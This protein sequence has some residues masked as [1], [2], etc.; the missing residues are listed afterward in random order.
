MTTLPIA[1]GTALWF[2][3]RGTGVVALLLATLVVVLGVANVRRVQLEGVPR[4]VVELVHRNAAL[5]AVAFLVVHVLTSVLDPFAPITLIDAVV[6]F[7]SA[8]RP[9]WLGLGAIASDLLLAIV[10]TSLVRRRLGHRA[11]RAIHWLAY[12]SWPVAVIHSLGTGSDAKTKWLLALTALCVIVVVAA[13]V[14]R[15]L[16]GWPRRLGARLGALGAAA[17]LPIGLLIWLPSGPLGRD[18]ARRSGTP[19]SV[20]AA[21]HGAPVA[22]GRRVS[23]VAPTKGTGAGPTSFQATVQGPLARSLE[24]GGRA[25]IQLL[26]TVAGERLSS[27]DVLIEGDEIAGGGVNMTSSSVTLGTASD[28]HLYRG[29]ITALNGTNITAVVSDAAGQTIH[30]QIDLQLAPS[31]QSAQGTVT[32]SA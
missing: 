2:L 3:T 23:R 24:G 27:L 1:S 6:P 25:S 14:A 31:G 30:L 18:W 19:A 9:F 17:A 32:A 21:A 4:F 15:V 10:I 7:L 26:L 22:A 28:P 11:W 5:L 29:R 16:A 8:Y 20:L 12:A 13:V